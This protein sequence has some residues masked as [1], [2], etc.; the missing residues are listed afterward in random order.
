MSFVLIDV[1]RT[2]IV[3]RIKIDK[4]SVYISH[5]INVSKQQIH[6]IRRNIKLYNF[7][8]VS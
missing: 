6:K 4:N 3:D 7:V 5:L 8:V 1:Q 2:A